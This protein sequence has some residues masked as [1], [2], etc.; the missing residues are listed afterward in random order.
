VTSAWGG[1]SAE[2][3]DDDFD[4]VD[5]DGFGLGDVADRGDLDDD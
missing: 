3:R 4:V 1:S 2:Y 5:V